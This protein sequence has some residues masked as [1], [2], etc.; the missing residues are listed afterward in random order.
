MIAALRKDP[1]E[2][3]QTIAAA[4]LS[5]LL[6]LAL[7][8]GIAWILTRPI[9]E[10]E[11]DEPEPLEITL[12]P[13]E[14]PKPAEPQFVRTDPANAL[15]DAPQSAAFE[16]DNN[17][18]AA[19]E[20]PA[21]GTEAVPS[22]EGEDSPAM[23][24]ANREYTAGREARPASPPSSAAEPQPPAEPVATPEPSE[25]AP[26]QLALRDAP[27]PKP[28]E[29]TAEAKPAPPTTPG[30]Q[31][32]TRV[33]RLRGNISNRGKASVEAAATPLGRYKKMI[34]DAIGSRWYYYVNEQLGLLNIGT[35][36]VRFVVLPDG[37]V[38]NV[39][40]LS[41]TSN[42]SFASVS[43]S[44]IMDAEIPPIPPDVAKILDNSRIEIDYS[45]TILSN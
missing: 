45:F 15:P 13:V 32:Q 18:R 27:P 34:S 22:M 39:E 9:L 35:V 16:S 43:V 20:A 25:R 28:R 2:R 14:A 36:S 17:T 21:T 31:P 6:H 7:I 26:T 38:R 1:R 10:A 30:F 8:G 29:P 40:V 44:A 4:I 3:R 11:K 19:S 12:M 24:L 37:K 5:V 41:N 33:T 23:E 42:E